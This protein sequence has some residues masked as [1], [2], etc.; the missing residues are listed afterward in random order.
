M[1]SVVA[2]L[3]VSLVARKF[4]RLAETKHHVHVLDEQQLSEQGTRCSN[5][6]G[7][8]HPSVHTASHL[9]H[10]LKACCALR[11]LIHDKSPVTC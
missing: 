1:A 5:L 11:N 7:V 9:Q 8:K 3:T 6:L 4:K 10:H 2:Q